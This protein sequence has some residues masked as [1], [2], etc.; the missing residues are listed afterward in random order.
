[1]KGTHIMDAIDRYF[2]TLRILL[3][4]H[5]RDDILRELSEEINDLL[6]G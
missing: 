4:K 3:P 6:F 2:R 5:E 1:M